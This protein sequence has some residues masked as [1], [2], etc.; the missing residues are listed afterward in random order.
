M[1]LYHNPLSP[2]AR[3]ALATAK[4][5]GLSIEEHVVDFMKGEHK[6]PSYLALNPNGMVPTLQ[7]GDFVLTESRVIAQYLASK[8]PDAGLLPADDRSRFDVQ[9]WS[10]WDAA[11]FSPPIAS[12]TFEKL[13]K[14]MLGAGQTD[15]AAVSAAL[16]RFERFAPILD[17]HLGKAGGW[18]V[19]GNLT[20]ADFIVGATLTYATPIGLPLDEH[21]QIKSWLGRLGELAAWRDTVP[22]VG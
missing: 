22:Q 14:P 4:H 13:L 17:A 19:G 1:K 5:L 16:T 10:T 3:R 15:E 21:K 12:I 8:K 20:V 7:D 2:N 6:E 18:L 11:H 9:R